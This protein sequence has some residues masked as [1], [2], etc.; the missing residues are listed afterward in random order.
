MIVRLS[1]N[2][3]YQG[4]AYPTSL[5]LLSPW[6]ME[7]LRKRKIVIFGGGYVGCMAQMEFRR[8]DLPIYGY[9]DNNKRLHGKKIG[10]H[11]I[12]S[13]YDLFQE[14]DIH[15]IVCVTEQNINSIRLQ[16]E[17]NGILDYSICSPMTGFWWDQSKCHMNELVDHAIHKIASSYPVPLK[18]YEDSYLPLGKIQ[19]SLNSVHFWHPIAEWIIQS[20]K[21]EDNILEL[22][23]GAGMLSA[24]IRFQN[25]Q[26]PISWLN[27][28][29]ENTWDNEKMFHWISHNGNIGEL[30]NGYLEN[31]D[32]P[33]KG[34]YSIIIMTEVMEHFLCNP[35]PTLKKIRKA[36]KED[37]V[38]YLSTPNWGHRF[39]YKTWRDMPVFD[40]MEEYLKLSEG[41]G[42]H[43]YQYD[44]EELWEVIKEADFTIIRYEE[45]VGGNHNLMLCKSKKK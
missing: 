44:K 29:Y 12:A 43:I 27:Y 38:L 36:L 8:Y 24:M 37:G 4:F 22:G 13:P 2:Q 14:S 11:I 33:I 19:Y 34:D 39:I 41:M 32:E 10:N 9:V 26:I 5:Y 3:Y 23:S 40:D 6:D 17:R 20:L 42:N 18:P 7:D 45:S 1:E 30:M 25:S 35:V 16:L 15:F 21:D 31:L 28:G